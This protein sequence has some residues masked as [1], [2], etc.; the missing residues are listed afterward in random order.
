MKNRLMDW[1]DEYG[2]L[3]LI[4]FMVLVVIGSIVLAVVAESKR[5]YLKAPVEAC[6]QTLTG[7]TKTEEWISYQCAAYDGK[8]NCTVQVPVTNQTTY[9]EVRNQCDWK[10]WR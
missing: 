7:N 5:E 10:V 3:L 2:P 1:L 6:V 9:Q 8:D 4:G